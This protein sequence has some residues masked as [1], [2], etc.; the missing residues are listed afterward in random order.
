MMVTNVSE[1][2]VSAYQSKLRDMS[3]YLNL[4]IKSVEIRAADTHDLML[5][6]RYLSVRVEV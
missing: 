6:G 1:T 3:K 4:P 5:D 2:S